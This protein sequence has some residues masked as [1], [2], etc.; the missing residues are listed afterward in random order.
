[1]NLKELSG[2]SVMLFGKSRALSG[3]EF[4]LKLKA[5]KITI[6]ESFGEEVDAIIEGCAVDPADE[7]RMDLL[8]KEKA[9]PVIGI[10]GLERALC[11]DMDAPRLLMSLKLGGDRERLLGYLKNPYVDNALFLKLLSL[12]D[13]GGEGFFDTDEN[14]DVT[15]ALIARHY[16]NINRNPNLQYVHL[17]LLHLLAQS[18]DAA[19]IETIAG[20]QPLK[21]GLKGEADSAMRQLLNAIGEH[22]STPPAVLRQC[23]RHG[24]GEL[25]S[26]IAS[27][28]D[29]AAAMQQQLADLNDEAVSGTLAANPQ[30][31]HGVARSLLESHG[32]TVAAHIGLDES[33]FD[34][35]YERFP[36][37]LATNPSLDL[38]MQRRLFCLNDAVQ[39]ALA[40]NSCLDAQM[41]VLLYETNKPQILAALAGNILTPPELLEQMA[42]DE[43]LQVVLAGNSNTPATVLQRLLRS[44]DQSVL[45]ALAQNSAAPYEM[46]CELLLER[47]LEQYVKENPGFAK[48]IERDH[49]GWNV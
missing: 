30:L 8:C 38:P 19:L 25:R 22:P 26:V 33:M 7:T 31:D 3:D 45:T 13:W 16:E 46:L 24:S 17:G 10:D 44:K 40:S 39:A 48:T 47:R 35:C 18:S 49:L 34:L 42:Q 1:M 9:L 32:G 11:A 4:R 29:L 23:I 36:E 28:A 37:A 15:A 12:Y 27:R 5:H 41:T 20:L 21:N 14:R 2:K 43:R 6:A